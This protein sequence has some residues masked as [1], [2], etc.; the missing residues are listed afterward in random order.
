MPGS[1]RRRRKIAAEDAA[2]AAK[3]YLGFHV[4]GARRVELEEIEFTLDEHFWLITLSYE[5][6]T[7]DF[8]PRQYKV[9]KIDAVTGEVRSMKIKRVG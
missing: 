6:S 4:P 1:S 7:L 8:A 9:F 3:A 2:S 5:Q